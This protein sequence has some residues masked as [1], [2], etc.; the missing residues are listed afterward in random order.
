MRGSSINDKINFSTAIQSARVLPGD[1]LWLCDPEYIFENGLGRRDIKLN[2][3]AEAPITIRPL[4]GVRVRINGGLTF[5]A[6]NCSYVILRDIEIGPTPTTRVFSTKEDVTIPIGAS[7]T[8]IGNKLI[9]CFVHDCAEGVAW[10]GSGV[11]EVYGCV[12]FNNG[13][14]T[15]DV[16]GNRDYGIYSHNHF[17]GNRIIKHN[18]F[19]K[20]FGAYGFHGYS[21]G[22]RVQDYTVE[23]NVFI[24]SSAIFDSGVLAED[25]RFVGNFGY[26]AE[27]RA[28]TSDIP[29]S[30]E[31]EITGNYL[32][33]NQVGFLFYQNI[34]FSGNTIISPA[35]DSNYMCAGYH[36]PISGI[37]SM[38]WDNN[39]YFHN[40]P[41]HLRPLGKDNIEYLFEDWQA[42]GLD[43]NSTYTRDMPTANHVVVLP[44]EYADSGSPRMGI[45][46]IYNYEALD[47]VGV[48]LSAL[49]LDVG[50]SYLWRQAQD[51]L[52]DTGTFVYTGN[53]VSFS[54]I[55][56]TVAI[57]TGAALVLA[58]STF[59]AFG[60]FV[61][62]SIP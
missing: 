26:D 56:H 30:V 23:A 45:V 41:A 57:P 35:G 12:F 52:N 18:V 44:N 24:Q 34:I 59:P 47:A 37:N 46:V 4:P 25:N 33:G 21:G 61:I 54:M 10:F 50:A 20:Q 19:C 5:L 42:L 29:A 31:V 7:L 22:N 49:N 32:Y 2:G 36:T 53:P 38:E 62:E 51:P 15:T 16:G 11:G 27:F 6:E 3:T 55:G 8:G 40:Q 9:N 39:V 14:H 43:A 48:D 58:G 1:T 13:Y 28:G 17:G 60:A